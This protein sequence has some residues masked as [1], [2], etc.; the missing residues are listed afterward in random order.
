[1]QSIGGG[2]QHGLV[3]RELLQETELSGG[4]SDL[5]EIVLDISAESGG[6]NLLGNL[7]CAV[8]HLL[9]G[10]GSLADIADLLNRILQAIAS[11]LG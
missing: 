6:G 9:D 5:S 8:T 1:M 4:R 2:G 7:L 3:I 10:P 11:V